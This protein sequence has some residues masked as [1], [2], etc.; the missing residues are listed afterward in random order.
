M[1]TMIFPLPVGMPPLEWDLIDPLIKRWSLW[2]HSLDVG[3]P[4]TSSEQKNATEMTWCDYLSHC[5][6]RPWR[7]SSSC[8]RR[9]YPARKLRLA[10]WKVHLHTAEM[11][12]SSWNPQITTE[13][14]VTVRQ[15][16]RRTN[17]LVPAQIAG[18]YN[19]EQLKWLVLLN[20]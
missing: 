13:T 19:H 3:W 16:S 12:H 18:T 20:H 6:K 7:F 11:S 15:T 5:V 4:V 9:C 10:C 14:Q 2:F 8:L 17:L 1:A